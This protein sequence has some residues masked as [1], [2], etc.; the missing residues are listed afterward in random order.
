MG[1]VLG[2]TGVAEPIYESLLYRSSVKTPYE[3]RQYATRYA[4]ETDY[5]GDDTGNAFRLL[6]GYIGVGGP[7]QNEV[8]SSVKMTAPVVTTTSKNTSPSGTQISM[9]A[10]VTTTNNPA[11]HSSKKKMQFYLPA[12]FDEMSKIPQPNNPNVKI[13]EVPPSLG[14]IHKF[15]GRVDDK[16]AESKV[17]SLVKQLNDDGLEIKEKDAIENYLLWQFNPPFTIPQFRRN[18]VWIPLTKEQ[19]EEHLKR[20]PDEKP[21][22]D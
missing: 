10:P 20:Y 17:A 16:K 18:E 11:T 6:A 1:M 12:E 19:V 5:S 2:K 8:S 4:I 14:V 7:P 15:G 22:S 21:S 9:T 3:I 13:Q